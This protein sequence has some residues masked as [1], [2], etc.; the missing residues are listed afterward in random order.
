MV[1]LLGFL[2]QTG[3]VPLVRDALYFGDSNSLAVQLMRIQRNLT[4]EASSS[5]VVVLE[6]V[7][8]VAVPGGAI[9]AAVAGH[10]LQHL[11]NH[12][13]YLIRPLHFRVGETSR[14]QGEGAGRLRPRR[15][16]HAVA[17]RRAGRGPVRGGVAQR[18][19]RVPGPG[20]ASPH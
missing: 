15:Q 12:P 3:S 17:Q 6:A 1:R 5:S 4:A 19:G 11:G 9:T 13:G 14:V 2:S 20:P 18:F 10:I 8:V 7:Q 16:Y